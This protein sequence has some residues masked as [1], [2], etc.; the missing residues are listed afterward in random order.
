M[1][2]VAKNMILLL[3]TDGKMQIQTLFHFCMAV[4]L[5]YIQVG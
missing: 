1:G 3:K 4:W 5:L 2:S